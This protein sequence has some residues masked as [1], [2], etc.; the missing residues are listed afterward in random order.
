MVGEIFSS[1][2][3]KFASEYFVLSS[4]VCYIAAVTSFPRFKHFL[5]LP[6]DGLDF[7]SDGNV[8]VKGNDVDVLA[9]GGANLLFVKGS[10]TI[11]A[12]EEV[13]I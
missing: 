6:Q 5:P 12:L 9:S 11:S 10:A 2:Q 7:V 3:S 8:T 13:I 1:K 4:Q